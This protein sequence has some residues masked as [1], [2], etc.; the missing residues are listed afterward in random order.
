MAT[1]HRPYPLVV[2]RVEGWDDTPNK[3]KRCDRKGRTDTTTD[4][5]RV[6]IAH[7]GH[8]LSNG[9]TYECSSGRV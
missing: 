4:E 3:D 5:N 8:T 1:A 6:L 7:S 9:S 2:R